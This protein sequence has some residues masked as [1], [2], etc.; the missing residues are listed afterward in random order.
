MC[1]YCVCI[2]KFKPV[3]YCITAVCN[4]VLITLFIV[5]K[6]VPKIF[7]LYVHIYSTNNIS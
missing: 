1:V 6:T 4:T 7:Q 2:V 3:R 5:N